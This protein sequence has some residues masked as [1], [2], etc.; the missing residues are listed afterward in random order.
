MVFEVGG[1]DISRATTDQEV[2]PWART[3]PRRRASRVGS[4]GVGRGG[5]ARLTALVRSSDSITKRGVRGGKERVG[6]VR[7]AP[8]NSRSPGATTERLEVGTPFAVADGTVS[9]GTVSDGAVADGAV[10]DG[11]VADGAVAEAPSP[12]NLAS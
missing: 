3:M 9:D 2:V 11:A 8:P 6:V 7:A 10:A 1:R 4:Q 12:P 5:R